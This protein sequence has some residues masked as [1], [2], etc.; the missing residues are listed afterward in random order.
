MVTETMSGDQLLALLDRLV[1]GAEGAERAELEEARWTAGILV[2]L[3]RGVTGMLNV[4][5]G[6]RDEYGLPDEPDEAEAAEA[7]Q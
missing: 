1:D 3:T 7:D 2:A 5:P 4:I 6:W